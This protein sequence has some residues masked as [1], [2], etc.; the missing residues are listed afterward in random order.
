MTN[1][2]VPRSCYIHGY[3]DDDGLTVVGDAEAAYQAIRAINHYTMGQ[4]IHAPVLYTVL[5]NL[6]LLG[7]AL[8]Q[9]LQQAQ[10]GLTTSLEVYE[11]YQDDGSDPAAAVAEACEL[12]ARA[13]GHAG[14]VGSLLADGQVAIN[15]QGY[16]H[17]DAGG[18]A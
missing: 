16:H 5:G 7:P 13:A 6:K 12:L 9:A 14:A 4:P 18:P 1:D 15:Q 11:V 17:H 2:A 3:P 8:A 10:T